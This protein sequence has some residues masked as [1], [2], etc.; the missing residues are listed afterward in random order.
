[1]TYHELHNLNS[2]ISEADGLEELARGADASVFFTCTGD[3]LLGLFFCFSILICVFYISHNY[4]VEER[5][6]LAEAE[7]NRIEA[8]MEKFQKMETH[9]RKMAKIIERYAIRL[10]NITSPSK[11]NSSD[12]SRS[13]YNTRQI[14]DGNEL[15]KVPIE[16]ITIQSDSSSDFIEDIDIK[17]IEESM[18]NTNTN[19]NDNNLISG[20]ACETAYTTT[21]ST[22]IINTNTGNQIQDEYSPIPSSLS[23]TSTITHANLREA[24]TNNPCAICL[25]SF[26][27]GDDIVCCSN[28]INGRKPHVFHQAC[29]LD[30]IVTHTEGIEA[31]CPCCRKL[32]LPSEEQRNGCLK[33]SHCSALTLPELGEPDDI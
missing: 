31:P 27:A 5:A 7:R 26:R 16:T 11:H 21:R 19:T 4:S 17:D 28:N 8:E 18:L 10:T 14:P 22:L 9:R 30:Y 2:T 13:N 6:E 3:A 15:D 12:N 25:E 1:M 23:I 24:V 29:S 33:H 20:N 32:L